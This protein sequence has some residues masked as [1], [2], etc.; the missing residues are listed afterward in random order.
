MDKDT[1]SHEQYLKER[2]RAFQ[3]D[4]AGS[5]GANTQTNKQF[6]QV[7]QLQRENE[8]L[9]QELKDLKMEALELYRRLIR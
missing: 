2:Q 8:S 3:E 9:R 6:N 5:V 7:E 1:Y 4:V